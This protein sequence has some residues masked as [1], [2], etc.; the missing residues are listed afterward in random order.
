MAPR[1]NAAD[2]PLSVIATWPFNFINPPET[3]GWGVIFLF[4]LLI[5]TTYIVVSLRIWARLRRSK[6]PGIDDALIVFNM[7]RAQQS[8]NHVQDD[9]NLYRYPWRASQ[10]LFAWPLVDMALIVTSGIHHFQSSKKPDRFL[11]PSN[12]STW[13]PHQRPRSQYS[14]STDD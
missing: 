11:C 2:P 8:Q 3:R 10:S 13:P 5:V 14:C 4:V 12:F 6:N 9:S 1:V 7:V